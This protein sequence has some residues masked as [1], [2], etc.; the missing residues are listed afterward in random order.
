MMTTTTH[1]L[2]RAR[3]NA[4]RILEALELDAYIYSVEP[5]SEVWELT[6]ECASEIDGGWETVVLEVP[7]KML[8]DRFDDQL[9]RQRLFAYW[10]KKL[11]AC[12][13]KKQ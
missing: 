2:A 4:Q 12:K 11:S 8:L 5:R 7:G 10:Q 1:E 6:V 9:A 3:D 13:L